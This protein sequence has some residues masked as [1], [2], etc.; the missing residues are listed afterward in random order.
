MQGSL[1]IARI[2]DIPVYVHWSFG[3]LFLFVAYMGNTW[4]G[5]LF[6]SI[7]VLALFVC[8]VMHEYGHALSAKKYGVT[9][10]DIIILP[11][12]GVA[13]LN[14]MPEKPFQEFIVAIAGPAVNV[15]IAI[16]LYIAK[17]FLET[18]L[19]T[20]DTESFWL[21]AI[22][23]FFETLLI[24]NIFLVVFNMIPAYPMDGGRVLRALL[25]IRLGRTRATKIASVLGQIFAVLFIIAA[26][27]PL[28][29]HFI[30]DYSPWGEYTSYIFWDFQPVL[31]L[32]S[33]FIFT[34]ARNE[35]KH[36]KTEEKLS[37][38]VVENIMRTQYTPLQTSDTI[39][40]VAEIA[41]KG[42]E[43]DFLVFDDT[44]IL[45]GV[46]QEDDI[47]DAIKNKHFDSLIFA[48]TTHE[49][50]SIMPLDT[51]KEAYQKMLSTGQYILPVMNNGKLEGVIDMESI[52][53]YMKG[54]K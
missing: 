24:S 8:V 21:T 45:R 1:K 31:A 27:L 46:L 38:E 25:S 26:L 44:E 43:T 28:L 3:L 34:T 22:Y 30:S 41:S 10:Q 6:Q 35:Y 13:R 53:K 18:Y 19:N 11:I 9:T 4:Q 20:H 12:G 17:Y 37:N 14:K 36:V 16:V 47:T 15:V 50:T 2:F 42:I 32:I 29:K 54:N 48:Y 51:L 40:K 23:E 39:Y 5:I 7:Y 49:F 52:Q 33:F